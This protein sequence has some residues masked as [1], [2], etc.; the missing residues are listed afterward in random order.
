MLLVP[1]DSCH[2]AGWLLVDSTHNSD[3]DGDN[4]YDDEGRLYTWCGSTCNN[5][6]EDYKTK[7]TVCFH[8]VS[9]RATTLQTSSWAAVIPSDKCVSS[10]IRDTHA[11]WKGHFCFKIALQIVPC[12]SFHDDDCRS[13]VDGEDGNHD[14]LTVTVIMMKTAIVGTTMERKNMK[15]ELQNRVVITAERRWIQSEA[16]HFFST[17]HVQTLFRPVVVKNI[18]PETLLI[19]HEEDF[20]DKTPKASVKV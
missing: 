4:D 2:R 8:V 16:A 18:T 17:V 19:W 12:N 3:D 1:A 5:E 20:K 7:Q 9:S 14:E 10:A 6:Q 15:G 13:G 11:C